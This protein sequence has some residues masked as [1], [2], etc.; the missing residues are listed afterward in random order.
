[1]LD[2][3]QPARSRRRGIGRRPQI[4]DQPQDLDEQRPRHGDLG[5]LEG[6]VSPAQLAQVQIDVDG[7]FALTAGAASDE[8]AVLYLVARGGEAA[9]GKRG[10]DTG[11]ALLAVPAS[12]L[13][14]R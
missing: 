10:E 1:M 2:L 8:D 7:H 6:D 13:N 4:S 3:V 11:L 12:S 9:A 14:E 5:H